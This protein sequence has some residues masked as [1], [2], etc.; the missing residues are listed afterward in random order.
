MALPLK[1]M[2]TFPA[3]AVTRSAARAEGA[4]LSARHNSSARAAAR[5]V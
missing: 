3:V 4:R 5:R 1:R 2:S